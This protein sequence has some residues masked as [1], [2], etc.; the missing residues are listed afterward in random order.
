MNDR[1]RDMK[2]DTFVQ[3]DREGQQ[4]DLKTQQQDNKQREWYAPQHQRYYPPGQPY[5]MPSGPPE[6]PRK[7]N[8]DIG[9]YVAIVVS[10]LVIV[11]ITV[12]AFFLIRYLAASDPDPTKTFPEDSITHTDSGEVT[13][14]T[15]AV[16]TTVTEAT[17]TKAAFTA[18]SAPSPTT[19]EEADDFENDPFGKIYTREQLS[20]YLWFDQSG[21][22]ISPASQASLAYFVDRQA[23][24][25]AFEYFTEV[26]LKS[27]FNDNN[28]GILHRW[29]NPV[30]VEVR[31][32]STEEDL[33]VLDQIIAELNAI[34]ALPS[35]SRVTTGGN[36]IFTF[37]LLDDMAEAVSGYVEGNWGFVSIFWDRTGDIDYAEAAIATDVMSQ[38][39]RSHIILEEFV[40]G[41]GMLNDPY[42]YPDSIFQQDWTLVQ[43]LM[44]I[45]WA[46]IRI[47]YHPALS[48]GLDSNAIYRQM[49]EEL[50][51]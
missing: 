33:K 5:Q 47:V 1:E 48:S 7:N 26:A 42:D 32:D 3:P 41:F 29:G 12:M 38:E 8:T 23:F 37:S 43:D 27:E 10:L 4:P 31:G 36:Y 22:G 24:D 15:S 16:I 2:S 19:A 44:P 50:F 30:L 9:V 35:I 21:Y 20:R 46:V 6:P 34:N 45:D 17:I 18:S 11:L 25:V 51:D 28:E 49:V 40:Q 14:A 39:E 13:E